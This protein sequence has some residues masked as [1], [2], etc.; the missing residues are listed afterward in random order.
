MGLSIED[1][2]AARV[3]YGVALIVG[4]TLRVIAL[5]MLIGGVVT[6][7]FGAG[8][9][10]KSGSSPGDVSAFVASVI[11][12][13]LTAAGLLAAAGYVVSLLVEIFEQ[14]AETRYA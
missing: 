14:T 4:G 11:A 6:A 7:G 3:Q 10:H 13:A 1:T 9:L 8:Q 12:V 5:L 2:S